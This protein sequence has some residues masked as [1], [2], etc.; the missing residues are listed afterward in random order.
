MVA[1][2]R[3]RTEHG[4]GGESPIS[5]IPD[6]L[7]AVG[8]SKVDSQEVRG[9]QDARM[10]TQEIASVLLLLVGLLALVASLGTTWV[11][12]GPHVQAAVKARGISSA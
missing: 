4:R 6:A 9:A 7:H 8:N 2:V 5:C 12:Y 3:N 1:T 10:S 11:L